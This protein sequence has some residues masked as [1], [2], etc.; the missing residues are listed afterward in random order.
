[1]PDPDPEIYPITPLQQGMVFN[2]IASE[3]GGAEIQ[4]QFFTFPEPFDIDRMANA[5]NTVIER[6]DMLHTRYCRLDDGSIA[7]TLDPT[8]SLVP[9]V[10][11]WRDVPDEDLEEKLL[12]LVE[13]DREQRLDLWV[14]PV[15]RV[16][17]V[18]ARENVFYLLWTFHHSLLDGRSN[19]LVYEEVF[20]LWDAS[21]SGHAP[22]PSKPTYPFRD[23][24]E[25]LDGLDKKPMEDYWRN[26]LAGF[27]APTPICEVLDAQ[28]T[29]L[30]KFKQGFRTI[31]RGTSDAIR[32]LAAASDVTLN[33][34][35]QGAWALLLHQYTREPDVVFAAT[36][37]SRVTELPD[38]RDRVGLFMNTLPMR[39]S[40]PEGMPMR[41]WLHQIRHDHVAHR[42]FEQMSVQDVQRCTDIAP[43]VPLFGSILLFENLQPKLNLR[44]LGGK[45][46]QRNL[47]SFGQTS[48]PLTL[49]AYGN[50][51]IY[52]KFE[53]DESVFSPDKME[54]LL[55][56]FVQIASRMPVEE[57][58]APTHIPMLTVAEQDRITED[59][60]ATDADVSKDLLL[61]ELFEASVGKD[62][63]HVA[64]EF[65]GESLTYAELD[66]LAN[67]LAE[68]L[69]KA[70]V[71]AGDL[72]G[73]SVERGIGMV[74]A[75]L[76]VLKAGAGYVPMDP[77]YPEARLQ[78]MLEMSAAS[79]VITHPHLTEVYSSTEVR[80]VQVD[81]SGAL[82][83]SPEGHSARGA[84]PR[85]VSAEDRAYVIFTSGSTG[86]PKGVQVPHRAAVNFIKS[87]VEE[88]GITP[89]DALVAVTTLSFDIHVLEIFGPLSVG[90]RVIVSS[91]ETATDGWKLLELIQE[92]KATIMQATPMTWRLLVEGG[93]DK[94]APVKALV[95]GE[96]LP[97][98]LLADLL[99]RAGQVWNMY[100]PTETT[101]WSTCCQITDIAAPILIGKPIA[102]TQTYI[103]DDH[104]N[105]LPP[106]IPGELLIG[107]RGVTLG[108]IGRPDL[109]EEN[110]VP[111]PF[112]PEQGYPLYRTGD[113]AVQNDDGSLRYLRRLDT[114]VKVKGYRIELAEI[115]EALSNH[116][117]IRTCAVNVVEMGSTQNLVA[118]YVSEDD[119]EAP[120]D[121]LRQHLHESLPDYMVPS[122]FM[123]LEVLPLT[124]NG[125]IDRKA[126]PKPTSTAP[127]STQPEES[128][129]TPREKELAEIWQEALGLEVVSV[130]ED[131]TSLG[132]DSLTSMRVLYRMTKLGIDE[133][134]CR[135]MFQGMTIRE[136]AHHST[137]SP[138]DAASGIQD[139]TNTR[140][141]GSNP[142][143][144][145]MRVVSLMRGCLVALVVA[146]HWSAGVVERLPENLAIFQQIL[147]PVFKLVTPG[148]AIV[149]GVSLGYIYFPLYQK[150]P[151]RTFSMLR[152]G[153]AMLSGAILLLAVMTI[154]EDLLNGKAITSTVFFNSFYSALMY[155]L[156]AIA[157]M[158]LWF[159]VIAATK[160]HILACIALALVMFIG[161]RV[162]MGLLV[163][164]EFTGF[165][166]LC[167]LMAVAKFNYFNMSVGALG[168][169]ALGLHL[170][171]NAHLSGLPSIYAMVGAAL[172]FAGLVLYISTGDIGRWLQR[173]PGIS[174]WMW[175]FYGGC[176]C[177]CYGAFLVL[178]RNDARF[179][180][181]L[182]GTIRWGEM[183][184]QCA[185]PIW[186]FHHL[187][188]SLKDLL[189]QVGFPDLVA[190]AIVLALFFGMS[191]TFMKKLYNLYYGSLYA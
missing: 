93:W 79:V 179:G 89:D 30:P 32:G 18:D 142:E 71:E 75:L 80:F 95:G 43:G 118:Y 28:E 54:R 58:G 146:A 163:G 172:L 82:L 104:L 97:R 116:P 156:L 138:D 57:L 94:S 90:A 88:P 49:Y 81:L 148:F 140:A 26:Y 115:E 87:M 73:V 3:R 15:V 165:V 20:G 128:A 180:T 6:H 98:D 101:V 77:A 37:A 83:A 14:A 12:A 185:L 108:Y 136:I 38:M 127:E 111:D 119:T 50:P 85:S 102:N 21:S 2:S 154:G 62:P 13:Q 25:W 145:A 5:W 68:S 186:I 175:V 137:V 40:C 11:N 39:V 174:L 59:W 152:M 120:N 189:D 117:A 170:K 53:Y 135:G 190:L 123:H 8:A 29:T 66:S 64:V 60:N 177:S 130:N 42:D 33:T 92:S 70:G 114:Q 151:K 178:I 139:F 74:A 47:V 52:L 187:T 134:T 126:L 44:T 103:A 166:Q 150:D 110:F 143:K 184:G 36:R 167:K 160:Y 155:Y 161:Y 46:A 61:H 9:V 67:V 182:Q 188:V 125:K 63:D 24:V 1:M 17:I 107:G 106:G 41:E 99:G 86:K 133:R 10:L 153:C 100:G 159:K 168:G 35:M 169:V 164:K 16:T 141:D 34:V 78:Y 109:T 131:F 51:E 191:Y 27:E 173:S 55:D 158:P 76:G 45:W 122:H 22:P 157:T 176:I 84:E 112:R 56:H 105:P 23:Y 65:E 124:P 96:A 171:R 48:F 147:T 91:R 121:Q 31:D 7:Q 162:A 181:V 183:A 149:F 129:S 72:V 132:G 69:R 113:L 144:T 4:Q 19:F